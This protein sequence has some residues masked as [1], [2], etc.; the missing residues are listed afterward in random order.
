M[1]IYK[2]GN[3]VYD[4]NDKNTLFVL[5]IMLPYHRQSIT[6]NSLKCVLEPNEQIVCY[7]AV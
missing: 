7:V 4:F 1:N 3:D 6:I 2:Q 5:I